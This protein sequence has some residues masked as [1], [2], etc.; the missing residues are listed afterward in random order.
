MGN[1]YRVE[2]VGNEFAVIGLWGANG[3]ILHRTGS[4]ATHRNAASVTTPCTKPRK[5]LVDAAMP[6]HA[7]MFGTS[8][9]SRET[10]GYWIRSAA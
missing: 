8:G 5:H 6:A 9:T 4:K 2:T 7:E 1:D 10:A 3:H